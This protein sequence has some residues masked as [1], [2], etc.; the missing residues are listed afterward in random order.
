MQSGGYGLRD[1]DEQPDHNGRGM[2]AIRDSRDDALGKVGGRGEELVILLAG[3][4][5]Q[6]QARDIATAQA[7][8]RAYQKEKR[9]CP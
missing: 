9:K 3:G 7:C 4:T 6:R 1:Q 2:G 5:K 8:W